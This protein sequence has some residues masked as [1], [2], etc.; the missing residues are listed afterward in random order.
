MMPPTTVRDCRPVPLTLIEFCEMFSNLPLAETGCITIA[1]GEPRTEI[2]FSVTVKVDSKLEFPKRAIAEARMLL[3]APEM[4]KV[5]N[6]IE[7]ASWIMTLSSQIPAAMAS[8]F[9]AVIMTTHP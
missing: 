3:F 7:A 1:E 5:D 8:V 9:G 4:L 2:L 6:R